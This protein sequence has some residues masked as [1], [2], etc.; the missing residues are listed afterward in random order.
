MILNLMSNTV[1]AQTVDN[2]DEDYIWTVCDVQPSFPGGVDSLKK[3]LVD[4]IV[5]QYLAPEDERT[6]IV[7]ARVVVEK[8]G[9]FSDVQILKGLG[10]LCDQ[11][12][13]RVI[14]LMPVWTP[15]TVKGEAV[16]AYF[17]FPVKFSE[18]A[19]SSKPDTFYNKD[20]N[21]TMVIPYGYTKVSK[22]EWK[23]TE[24]KGEALLEETFGEADIK[25]S[26]SILV[27][28]K[29][30]FNIVNAN[31]TPYDEII[32]GDFL[33]NQ[34]GVYEIIYQAFKTQLPDAAIDS[35]SG[36]EMIDGLKFQT[37]LVTL[38]VPNGMK[39][40]SKL[41]S[42]LFDKK[43]FTINFTYVREEEGNEMINAWLNSRFE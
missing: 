34:Q 26:E 31:S 9:Q 22:E 12:T 24:A 10:K 42:R 32:D 8:N 20:F 2:T 6:G 38:G 27:L 15:G 21:W 18:P 25:E 41:Y 40:Y 17:H 37:Y 11:E 13:L 23:R 29:G 35:V 4:N 1:K 3:F 5:F 36:E 16:R 7:F 43:Y 33:A 28:Q 14:G 19:L 39:V 30:K